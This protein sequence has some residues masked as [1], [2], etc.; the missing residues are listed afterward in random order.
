MENCN[1]FI[2]RRLTS[3]TGQTQMSRQGEEFWRLKVTRRRNL[4]AAARER[5][6]VPVAWTT[7]A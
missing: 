6:R 2:Y 1:N 4:D 7:T 3:D 5:Q